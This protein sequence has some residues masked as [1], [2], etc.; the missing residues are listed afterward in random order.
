MYLTGGFSLGYGLW[1][2]CRTRSRWSHAPCRRLPV[3]SSRITFSRSSVPAGAV[4]RSGLF[5]VLRYVGGP[6]GQRLAAAR[7]QAAIVNTVGNEPGQSSAPGL[8]WR[9][10]VCMEA[11]RVDS[12]RSPACPPPSRTGCVSPSRRSVPRRPRS[13]QRQ[14]CPAG[15]DRAGGDRRRLRRLSQRPDLPDPDPRPGAAGR[16]RALPGRPRRQA[17]D[18][19]P[20]H[21][22]E[23]A[24]DHATFLRRLARSRT[25]LER[26]FYLVVP[27]QI[28]TPRRA[29]SFRSSKRSTTTRA[30]AVR[31]QLTARCEEVAAP[32]SAAAVSPRDV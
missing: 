26:R 31:Q 29:A 32:A 11:A 16:P 20:E 18:Q 17:R 13:G 7:A 8:R 21:L 3:P 6:S 23:L 14:L 2:Q 1:N 30:G 24:H 5:V 25:L 28:E 12:G 15:R 9:E 19:L 27:A 22:A 4:S 10:E